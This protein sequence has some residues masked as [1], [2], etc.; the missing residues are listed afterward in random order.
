M[1]VLKG[2]H[3][4]VIVLLDMDSEFFEQAIFIL[5]PAGAREKLDRSAALRE[6]QKVVESYLPPRREEPARRLRGVKLLV[7]RRTGA[8]IGTGAAIIAA[9]SAGIYMLAR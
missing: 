3:K 1:P 5:K 4:N 2:T 6:A 8:L 9:V 7:R